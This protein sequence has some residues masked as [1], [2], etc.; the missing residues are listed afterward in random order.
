ME[1]TMFVVQKYQ[2]RCI[3]GYLAFY[4]SGASFYT[5]NISKANLFVSV[6]EANDSIVDKEEEWIMPVVITYRTLTP[7]V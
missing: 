2:G 3:G 7:M 6:E 5:T 1:T 4:D